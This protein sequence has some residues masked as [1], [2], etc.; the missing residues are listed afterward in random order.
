MKRI[1]L[2]ATFVV[3]SAC[4][5][6][7]DAQ[8][9]QPQEPVAPAAAD[10]APTAGEEIVEK[11]VSPGAETKDQAP[12]DTAPAEATAE[13]TAETAPAP[14][15]EPHTPS[16]AAGELYVAVS[17][18]NVRSGPGMAH[19]VVN[20]LAFNTPV[21]NLGIENLIWVKIAEGQYISRK[22]MSEE[23][24]TQPIQA[25]PSPQPASVESEA[26]VEAPAAVEAPEQPTATESEEAEAPAEGE[27]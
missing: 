8:T 20:V 13:P 17:H 19:D 15:T 11:S 14:T 1:V 7:D 26:P 16:A 27:N 23:K 4:T 21:P 10:T 12:A 5:S 6:N 22:Y 18:L 25:S 24:N 2:T 9:A 3:F